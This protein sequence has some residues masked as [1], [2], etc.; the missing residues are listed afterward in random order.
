MDGKKNWIWNGNLSKKY[1]G[2][3]INWNEFLRFTYIYRLF[4]V[5]VFSVTPNGKYLTL[6]HLDSYL[7][8]R[9]I[10]TKQKHIK[11]TKILENLQLFELDDTWFVANKLKS[12]RSDVISINQ[13][14]FGPHRLIS[15]D[16][17]S[18][19]MSW[20]IPLWRNV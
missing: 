9:T 15:V 16:I 8:T 4:Y 11:P 20:C 12:V 6:I 14:A 2:L 3:I 5:Y 13:S 1:L 17:L 7:F 19:P 18:L 10:K